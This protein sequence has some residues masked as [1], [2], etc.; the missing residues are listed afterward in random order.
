MTTSRGAV[1]PITSR[2]VV[3]Q[4]TE[5]LRRA[6][7]AGSL[8]PGAEYSLRELAGMLD[9][10]FIPVREALRSLESEGLV[11]MR[12]GRSLVIAP[13]DLDDLRG[14]YRL[15][16]ALEPEIARRSCVL[17][18]DR[19]LEL[20]ESR[21]AEFGAR[22]HGMADIYDD[23]HAFHLAL[24]APAATGWDIRVLTTLW[25]AGERYIRIGFG[26]LDPD[27]AEHERRGKAHADLLA[28]F[29]TRD[30]DAVAAAV[31]QHLARNEKIAFSALS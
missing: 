16:R 27:P 18:T 7:L 10:S 28:A 13:L 26:R 20:L 17:L 25:R 15:R 30:P 3:E 8:A 5:E 23:H 11:I 14:I 6:I 24:L 2:S 29:R 1:Q 19:E 4:A 9:I 12:P 21:A 31:E 22:E